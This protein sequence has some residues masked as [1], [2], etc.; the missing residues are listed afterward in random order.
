[1]SERRGYK[2]PTYKQWLYDSSQTK[3]KVTKWREEKK[4]VHSTDLNGED[5]A[6]IDDNLEPEEI[7]NTQCSRPQFDPDF[8]DCSSYITTTSQ[9]QDVDTESVVASATSDFNF[10]DDD[11]LTK[12]PG[13]T[14]ETEQR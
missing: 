11:S 4:N 2:R 9:N 10:E 6:W 8:D 12:M 7:D 13:S 1:M 14:M 5:S 3:P